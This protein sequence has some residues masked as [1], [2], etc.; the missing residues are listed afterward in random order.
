M[1]LHN[2]GLRF[3]MSLLLSTDPS[4]RGTAGTLY[5]YGKLIAAAYVE[6]PATEGR[7]PRECQRAATALIHWVMDL[8]IRSTEITDLVCETPQ[9]YTMG[10]NKTKGDPNLFLCLAGINASLA[11]ILPLVKVSHY[12]PHTWK[13]NTSKPKRASEPYVIETRLRAR[14][15]ADESKAVTWPRAAKERWDVSDSAAIGLYHL[16]RFER[17]RT[18]ARE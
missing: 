1:G 11:T 17:H 8:G 5:R 9:I 14:L 6:S 15:D 4:I 18:F 10:D 13:Q 3:R 7:G 2:L 16:G 12:T